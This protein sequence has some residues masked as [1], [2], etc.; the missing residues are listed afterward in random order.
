[1]MGQIVLS[2]TVLRTAMVKAYVLDL[3]IKQPSASV[4]LAT[5]VKHVKVNNVS[6]IAVIRVD[7]QRDIVSVIMDIRGWIVLSRIVSITVPFMVVVQKATVIVGQ[8]TKAVLVKI[9]CV[10]TIVI[11]MVSV[12]MEAAFANLTS[13]G[14]TAV[15][16]N[17]LTNAQQKV[18]VQKVVVSAKMGFQDQIVQQPC[19]Y[20]IATVEVDV[21]MA[22]V[23]VLLCLL[24]QLVR[25][26]VARMTVLAKE[27]VQYLMV[28][29]VVSRVRQG[30][31]VLLRNVLVGVPDMVIA[32][33]RTDNATAGLVIL[34]QTV[35]K[36]NV[37]MIVTKE[38]NVYLEVTANVDQSTQVSVVNTEV[39]LTIAM[40]EASV[41]MK[42]NVNVW[43][44]IWEKHVISWQ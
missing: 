7:V 6:I 19:V 33:V 28:N 22:N 35:P 30:K 13:R 18:N 42:V 11:T 4:L 24:D 20:R 8:A 16:S 29:V 2:R 21:S 15:N 44:A 3:M 12:Q 23:N 32:I 36:R 43:Q 38:A 39:V 14:V 41:Q 5:L 9:E 31:I 1:M 40:A 17:A 26:C 25:K 37:L 10:R 27:T 34:V